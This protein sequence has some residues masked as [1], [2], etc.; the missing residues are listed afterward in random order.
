MK[1][2]MCVMLFLLNACESVN[3]SK[4][5]KKNKSIQMNVK[6]EPTIKVKK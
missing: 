2:F 6:T 5:I 3:V 1:Y 4:D